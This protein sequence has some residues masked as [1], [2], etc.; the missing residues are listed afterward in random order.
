MPDKRSRSGES[1][2]LQKERM[3]DMQIRYG[4]LWAYEEWMG[5]E[6]IPIYEGLA[7]VENV[8][9]LP[10][11]PWARM[12][13]LGTF[14]QL[15]GTKQTGALHYVVEIPAGAALEPEKHLYD[16]LIYVLRGRGLTELWQEVGPKRSFEWGEGSLF[17]LPLNT[18]H[19]LV[20]G[21]REPVLLFAATNA[22]VVMETFHNTDFIFNCNYNFT[23]RYRGE[24]DYFLA[25]KER[26]QVGV[27]PVWETNFIPDMRTALLDDMFVKVAGGQI[28]FFNMAGWVWN[29]ASE[30]PVGRYHKAH[31]HGPGIV[32]LGLNSEGYAL[33]W[34]KEYGPHPYQDGHGDKVIRAPWKPGG[35]Y[36]AGAGPGEW[37]HQ[38]FNTGSEP[39][40]HITFGAGGSRFG[41]R[42]S[43]E[44]KNVDAAHISLRNGGRLVE[45]E[46]EDPEIRRQFIKALKKN[47]VECT[48]ESV[49]Y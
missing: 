8:A 11:R 40:R 43:R 20:N 44:G 18:R 7:G 49:V 10:R 6:G 39:A 38:H 9:E 36:A 30:W 27:R 47:G 31:Y 4:V 14:I 33:V 29:H 2:A 24:A 19:R 3:K 26:H 22:P 23:D 32:L 34:P 1:S 45:Y 16:E 17:A 41:E 48:M 46:D 25:G 13:G 21:G 42:M 15:E 37:F 28:T 5:K 12:G 35:I